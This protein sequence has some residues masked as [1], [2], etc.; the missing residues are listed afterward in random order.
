[1]E[2]DLEGSNQTVSDTDGELL[3]P[4]RHAAMTANTAES[5][6]ALPS[7]SDSDVIATFPAIGRSMR[8]KA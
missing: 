3:I 2:D 6:S 4:G 8:P 5:G 1:M 7:E